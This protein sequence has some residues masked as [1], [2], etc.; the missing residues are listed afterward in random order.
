MEKPKVEI[1]RELLEAEESCILEYGTEGDMLTDADLG[2]LVGLKSATAG[3]Y[4]SKIKFPA[5]RP[6]LAA[7]LKTRAANGN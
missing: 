7:Y 5:V 2:R 1:I 6:R 4:R 3:Q